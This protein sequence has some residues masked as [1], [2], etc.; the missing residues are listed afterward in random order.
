MSDEQWHDERPAVY[1]HYYM[2]GA[3]N[4]PRHDGVRTE[5]YKLIDFYSQNSGKGEFE[6]Y[7]LEKDPYEVNNVYADP[8]YADVREMMHDQLKDARNKYEVPDDVF[9]VPYV[10]MNRKERRELGLIKN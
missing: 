2:H 10:Y 5:R 4:V 7:D 9:E 1:Y 8:N 6:L 3:H